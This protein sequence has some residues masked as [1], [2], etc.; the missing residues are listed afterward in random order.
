ME[1]ELAFMENYLP[2]MEIELALKVNELS[3]LEI[4]IFEPL[5]A[6]HFH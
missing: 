1:I 3:L 4:G 5:G 6:I 2:L